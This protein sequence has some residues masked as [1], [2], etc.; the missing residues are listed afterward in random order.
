[1]TWNPAQEQVP[2]LCK[3]CGGAATPHDD[4]SLTCAYC[5][6]KDLLPENQLDRAIELKRRVVSA[7]GSVAQLEGLS[8]ALASIFEDRRAFVRVAAPWLVIAVLIT[9]Y[10]IAGSWAAISR[11]PENMRVSLML[12]ALMGTLFTSG[13]ALSLM[14]ALFV[15]RIHFRR[16]VRPLLIGRPPREPGKPARCRGCGG[17]LPDE[18]GPLIRCRFCRTHS[19]VTPELQR[20]RSQ[21]LEKEETA[22][23]QKAI[24]AS[25]GQQKASPAMTRIMI[26]AIVICYLSMFGVAK[27]ATA[28]LP[29]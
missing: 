8:A 21:L 12:Y 19:L 3:E 18:R 29:H 2:I 10:Q 5:G 23:R 16:S 11:A 24:K 28:L 17:D 7:A 26:V 4:L 14:L 13:I 22:Y 25:R 20:D 1:M 27:L 9:A 6:A 15:G